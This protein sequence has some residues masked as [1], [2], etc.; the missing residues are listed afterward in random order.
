MYA[1]H[2]FR[3]FYVSFI[4]AG[5]YWVA[6]VSGNWVHAEEP[7]EAFVKALL[8]AEYYDVAADYL[9]RAQN[10]ELVSAGFRKEIPYQRAKILHRSARA[11][12]VPELQQQKLEQADQ[13][14]NAYASGLTDT[15][16]KVNVL[17]ESANIK[18]A[19]SELHLRRS[20]NTRLG[21]DEKTAILSEADQLLR[22]AMQQYQ[23]GEDQLRSALENFQLDPK[24][25][26]SDSEKQRL[27]KQFIQV[28]TQ[29]PLV[30][31]KLADSL[32]PD[33]PERIELLER[34]VAQS[35][36]LYEKYGQAKIA[37]QFAFTAVTNGA[38]AAQKLGDHEKAIELLGHVFEINDGVAENRLKKNA[39]AVA[40]NSWR[41][42]DPYPHLEIIDL[43]D[44]R[45]ALLSRAQQND[46]GWQRIKLELADAKLTQADQLRGSGVTG[47]AGQ[48]KALSRDA[49]KLVRKIAR[50]VGPHSAYAKTIAQ[51]WDLSFSQIDEV[52]VTDVKSFED[53]KEVASALSSGL[54]ELQN[55][56]LLERRQILSITDADQRATAQSAIDEKTKALR[57][58][59]DNALAFYERS[60]A[61]ADDSTSREE[62][63]FIRYQ[64]TLG[65]FVKGETLQSALIAEFLLEKYPTV[66]W[67]RQ[68]SVYIVKG[69]SSELA[70]ISPDVDK[71]YETDKLTVACREIC[72]RWPQSNQSAIAAGTAVKLALRG[73][74]LAQAEEYFN[75]IPDSISTKSILAAKLGAAFWNDYLRNRK[76]DAAMRNKRLNDC[77]QLLNMV[78]SNPPE[79]ITY[80]VADSS[81]ILVNVLLE[82]KDFTEAIAQ[83]ET[84][85]LAPMK[86]IEQSHPAVTNNQYADQFRRRTYQ[87]ALKTY[88]ASMS[89]DKKE[90]AIEKA[91]A[92]IS[93]MQLEAQ[94]SKDPKSLARL[95]AVYQSAG[96]SLKAQFDSLQSAQQR[97]SFAPIVSQFVD[98]VVQGSKDPNTLLWAAQSLMKVA[99]ALSQEGSKGDAAPLFEQANRALDQA[100]SIGIS[101]PQ[102][103]LRLQ[104]LQALAFRGEG[105]YEQSVNEFI[106]LLKT[107]QSNLTWQI[108]AAQTL[109]MWGE[110]KA[111]DQAYAKALTGTGQTQVGKRKR[112]VVWGWRALVQRTRG[113]EKFND[114]FRV[115]VY[116]SVKTRFEYGVLKNDKKIIA[117]SQR[118]LDKAL[119]R[120]PF[121]RQGHWKSKFEA[122]QAKIQKNQ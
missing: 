22:L 6:V 73:Q 99:S 86:L 83:L 64:Q 25:P 62:I 69:F 116:N 61:L 23:L 13:L 31:E 43:L 26:N 30:S 75:L 81:L 37:K 117:S 97:K 49:N 96:N 42:I 107:R 24:D 16:Q 94:S 119:S 1:V 115:A 45:V 58:R 48:A 89:G 71:R 103:V 112:N 120:F 40:V 84:G 12:R 95:A 98:T 63:N 65:H 14:L 100:K 108:D 82:K 29:L 4:I 85:A 41:K 21:A 122:L 11:V 110:N 17:I 78:V 91:T 57:T 74:D 104:Y 70:E 50:S 106:A 59:S 51:R 35:T 28:R 87:A 8:E 72:K 39:F 66:R 54:I 33:S 109:Q 32:P 10:S 80:S 46:P 19:R 101:D 111:N 38:R 102:K 79:K 36:S 3:R 2:L 52:V 44:K 18:L 67:T 20:T 15:R 121:L 53:A 34:A 27:R 118:E 113:N 90:S 7:A 56:V 114:A 60:L 76:L 93:N 92:I 77:N 47:A 68:A 88:L 9:S 105:Q 55:E 5:I